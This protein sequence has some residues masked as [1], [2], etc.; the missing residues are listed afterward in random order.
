MNIEDYLSKFSKI[1][2]NPNLEAMEWLLNE[3]GNP[4]KNVK[5]IHIA[6]TNGKGSICEM[7]SNILFEAGLKV[8]KFLSPH[9]IKFND[10]VLVNQVSITD[11]E[12]EELLDELSK[13]IDKYNDTHEVK[14]KWFEVIT[15]L[16]LVY[17]SRKKCDI[18]V[19]ETGLGGLTDC[20]NIVQSLISV[21]ANIG[22]DHMDILGNT[23]EEI[24][25]HKA[26]IIKPRTD[27]VMLY[28]PTVTEIVEDVCLEKKA[29]LH[30]V[31]KEEIENYSYNENYQSFDY[32]DYKNVEISLKG[33]EQI[34]NAATVLK[35]IQVLK[36]KGYNISENAIRKALKTVIHRAR[37]EVLYNNPTVIFD[38]GHNE[39]AIINFVQ[40][41]NQYY[42]TSEKVFIISIL[43]TKD[44]KK[45]IQIITKENGLFYFTDGND[46]NK[47]VSKEE[48][49]NEAKKY[50]NEDI[51]MSD[52]GNAVD[53]AVNSYKT[54]VV[55][56]IGSFYV[57]ADVVRFF[58]S[59]EGAK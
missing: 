38:G 3:F 17:F 42:K 32:L 35:I 54:K 29:K 52:L 31:H 56:I 1:T 46:E 2:E 12:V 7:T 39:N 4:H 18:V 9:L 22:Y 41:L 26:G 50:L 11:E 25:M 21:I 34:Y 24:T 59:K 48:L 58:E 30:I 13:K 47:Y 37:F 5:Y 40:T 6:G 23:L 57:Y 19:L 55:C 28:Q 8:G 10:T 14:V 16:A 44:Y 33:K 51:Y 27:T 53:F 20:T 15:T 45:I 49:Y 36:E 43:K